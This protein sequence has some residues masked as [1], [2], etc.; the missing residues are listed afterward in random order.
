M[1]SSGILKVGSPK[2]LKCVQILSILSNTLSVSLFCSSGD[3]ALTGLDLIETVEKVA[4]C[5]SL[6]IDSVL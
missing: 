3:L 2:G 6:S 4:S 1:A 5:S